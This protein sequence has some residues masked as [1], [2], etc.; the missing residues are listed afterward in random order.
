LKSIGIAYYK[1][2]SYGTDSIT[3]KGIK[4]GIKGYVEKTDED[5]E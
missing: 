1:D 2:E 3:K 5:E 4:G